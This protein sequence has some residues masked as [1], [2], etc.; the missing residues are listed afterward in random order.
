MPVLVVEAEAAHSPR[1]LVPAA[2]E[3]IGAVEAEAE[4]QRSSQ[5][6]PL[7]LEAQEQMESC[8]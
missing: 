7:A 4:A 6:V 1:T 2:A 5:T 3:A 8:W